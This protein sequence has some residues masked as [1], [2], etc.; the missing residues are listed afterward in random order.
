[1]AN[2]PPT[3]P[4]S[5]TKN[6]QNG[7]WTSETRTSID[8]SSYLKNIPKT[9]KTF[10]MNSKGHYQKCRTSAPAISSESGIRLFPSIEIQIDVHDVKPFEKRE[11]RNGIHR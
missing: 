4:Q 5:L 10:K 1:M 7:R 8:D 2:I 6:C 9:M 3:I 11:I